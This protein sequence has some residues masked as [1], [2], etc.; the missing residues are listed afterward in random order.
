MSELFT[1]KCEPFE[2]VLNPRITSSVEEVEF[3]DSGEV[4]SDPWQRS[5]VSLRS[6]SAGR[7]QVWMRF[8]LRC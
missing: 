4:Y 6:S 7:H 8:V 3:E 5:L 1:P 2:E